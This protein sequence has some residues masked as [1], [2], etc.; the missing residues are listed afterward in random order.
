MK[1]QKKKKNPVADLVKNRVA[2]MSHAE[3]RLTAEFALDELIARRERWVDDTYRRFQEQERKG[4]ASAFQVPSPDDVWATDRV[5]VT[6]FTNKNRSKVSVGMA[7]LTPGDVFD[8]RT[9]AAIAFARAQG[10][11]VPDLF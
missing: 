5:I 4:M 11:P 2:F 9:G 10:K 1:T 3:L 8:F 6:C 7:R